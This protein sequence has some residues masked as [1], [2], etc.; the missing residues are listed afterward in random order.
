MRA[1]LLVPCLAALGAQLVAC[2]GTAPPAAPIAAR[3]AAAD[4]R[5]PVV[6][7]AAR[8][9][10]DLAALTAL[11]LVRTRR[12]A[13]WVFLPAGDWRATVAAAQLAAP[14]V[15]AL[16]MPMAGAYAGA[17][18]EDLGTRVE[19]RGYP[20]AARLRALVVGRLP[21][22][23]LGDLAVL[24]LGTG[25]VEARDPAALA[26]RLAAYRAGFAR[27]ASATLLI[28][29][30]R[31][32]YAVAGAAWSALSGDTLVLAGRGGLA[33]ASRRLLA[34]RARLAGARPALYLA[35]PRTLLPDALAR[36]LGR[37]GRVRRV[38]GADAAGTAV[39]LARFR[40]AATGFGWGQRR[41][42]ASA[43]V[44]NPHDGLAA[45]A[46]IMLSARGP[47][48]PVLLTDRRGRLPAVLRSHLRGLRSPRSSA[49]VLGDGRAVTAASVAAIG[50]ALS[51]G[52]VAGGAAPAPGEWRPGQ[53]PATAA[54]AFAALLRGAERLAS[55]RDAA[56]RAQR[57][58][59]ARAA[60]A[61]RAAAERR[62]RRE[63][64][65]LRRR[66]ER[67]QAEYRAALRRAARARS[68]QQRRLARLQA[69]RAA[70]LRR[71]AAALRK[72]LTEPGEECARAEVAA[73]YRCLTGRPPVGRPRARRS[74]AP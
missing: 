46:A 53:A 43:I 67:A 54:P 51:G 2:G 25:R 50:A 17:A 31:R 60:A 68:R 11:A 14:P 70:A 5:G 63:R 22:A 29:P 40:D 59:R 26:A 62:A 9:G 74:P 30:D 47:R 71:R 66:Y 13:G 36:E 42:P 16:L 19:V 32:A 33:P 20:R 21:R 4:V 57:A 58:R 38:A 34:A 15:G 73:R 12:P 10:S 52:A 37:F 56:R 44:V 49:W 72:L 18:A 8:S 3:A 41:G 45:A 65:R 24:G 64:A 35:G 23:V 7:L 48:A 28:V 27:R 1:R 6:R 69:Q 55:Q 61:R 39:A